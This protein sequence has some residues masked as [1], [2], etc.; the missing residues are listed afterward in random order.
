MT[1]ITCEECGAEVS[2]KAYA[3]P[4]CGYPI[5]GGG[6]MPPFARFGWWGYE[7]K[8]ETTILGIPLVH[9]ALG[10]NTK[11]GGLH[12][13]RGIIAVGQ[14][15]IGL[16]TIAQFGIGLLFAGGQFVAGTYAIGQFA[17]GLLF[18]LGQFATGTRV[19]G[20][21]TRRWHILSELPYIDSLSRY[22]LAKIRALL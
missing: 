7:W 5:Q 9:V 11:T 6:I 12:V 15:G 22:G 19:M 13:A 17:L 14:F 18:G 3:C 4:K 16:V 1:L 10:W 8:S 21:F 20:Q 2:D